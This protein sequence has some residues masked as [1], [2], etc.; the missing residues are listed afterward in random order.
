[1]T[2]NGPVLFIASPGLR[3]LGFNESPFVLAGQQSV[4]VCVCACV[5]LSG[6][7]RRGESLLWSPLSAFM[8]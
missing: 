3:I 1:M 2:C 8:L 5:P 7:V 4:S 6:D